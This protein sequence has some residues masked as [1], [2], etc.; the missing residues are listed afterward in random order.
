MIGNLAVARLLS[1]SAEQE[2][3]VPDS[4]EG[5]LEIASVRE[6]AGA[7][8]RCVG[9]LEEK[10]RSVI[11]DHY[12]GNLSLKEAGER[13]GLSKSWTSRIHARALQKLGRLCSQA[14]LGPSL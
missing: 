4:A 6:F 7:L 11:E 13:L 1:L 2:I 12:F 5:P 8:R 9:R 3:N 10:E 14:G